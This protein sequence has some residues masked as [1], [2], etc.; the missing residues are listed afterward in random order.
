MREAITL[1]LPWLL[2]AFTIVVMVMAGN[3][4]RLSWAVGLL[5]QV[6]WLVWIMASQ[7]W[8]LLPSCLVLVVVY[9]RNHLKWAKPAA[10]SGASS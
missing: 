5:G 7:S 1:Y 10:V 3:K 6:F 4:H 2:S 8:G 9:G